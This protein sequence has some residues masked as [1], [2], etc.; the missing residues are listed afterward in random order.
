MDKAD[1]I[2]KSKHIYPGVGSGVRSGF[3][4]IQGDKIRH[5]GALE[6]LEPFA[7][8]NTQVIDLGER[9]ILPGFHDAHLHA[10]LSGLYAEPWVKVSLTDTSEA[11]CVAGL[12]EVAG[13]VEKDRW[14]IGAG[15]Y[16]SLW[17]EPKLPTKHSLDAVY[18]DRPVAMI[19]FDCHTLWVNSFGMARLGIDRHM[20][21]P[22]GGFIDRDE[23]GEVL[24][25]FHETAATSLLRSILDFPEE[26]VDGFFEHLMG[27]LNSYGITSICDMSLMAAPGMDFIRDD[28]YRRMEASG[29]LTVRVHMYPTMVHGLE[30][31]LY[32]RE[33]YQGPM[34]YCNGVKHFFDG[35]SACHTA[36]LK[37]PYANAYYPGDVGKTTVP[38]EEMRALVLEAH[39]HDFS[40]R[41]HTIG[42]QA[43]HLMLDYCQDA[44][45]EYGRKPHLQHTL[46]HLENFQAEDLTRLKT[47]HV[48]PSVQPAHALADPNGVERD[49]GPE[50]VKLMW[51]FRSILDAG[52]IL[53]F[54][55][56]SPVVEVDPFQGIYNAVTRQSAFNG[57]PEG[58]WLPW[59]KIA[60]WE[61]VSAYTHGA[62]CA[63][64]ASHLYGT[65]AP[66]MY[67]DLCV[68]D[69][70]ILEGD[71]E[72]ILRTSC[73]M[74]IV[75]GQIVYKAES[76]AAPKV[77]RS[78]CPDA[79]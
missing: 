50:R 78:L 4:A 76:K 26:E 16:H 14:L 18:P 41:V 5:L 70:N 43:I 29:K 28:V 51:P 11:Q 68:L 49:L 42:D 35:V 19:S 67:A 8:P 77:Q 36:Y 17:D 64:N 1:L 7:G 45:A 9:L 40:I 58:G 55:T 65:L 73:V 25:T 32:M 44:E 3:V 69:H 66:G 75:G 20:P 2:L 72:D 62:A 54:G 63:A 6:E 74:T 79:L 56:D 22:P 47:A 24:G 23:D 33:R 48:L 61:A 27:I 46:E 38:P 15:W 10:F 31:P 59:E 34:L 21:D 57:Q 52:A 71:P 53:A 12:S 13:L 37:E 60:P 39:K 30:R